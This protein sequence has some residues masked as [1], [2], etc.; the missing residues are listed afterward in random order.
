MKL[1]S[2]TDTLT[3][4]KLGIFYS[5]C[6]APS[7]TLGRPFQFWVFRLTV[8]LGGQDHCSSGK[9]PRP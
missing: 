4:I 1:E 3:G 2:S 8:H 7:V 5:C 9:T 6:P